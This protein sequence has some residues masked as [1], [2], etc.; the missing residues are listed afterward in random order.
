MHTHT[1]D[2]KMECC[3]GRERGGVEVVKEEGKR[4]MKTVNG[5]GIV[6]QGGIMKSIDLQYI[7][8]NF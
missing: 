7:C 2:T 8:I 6:D 4:G 1:Y 3:L 5:H